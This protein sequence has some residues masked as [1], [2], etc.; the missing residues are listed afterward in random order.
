MKVPI[1]AYHKISD[2]FDWGITAVSKKAFEAQ[3]KYLFENNFQTI[4][5]HQ[6]LNKFGN[7]N[8]RQRPVII[9]FDDADE[10]VFNAAFPILKKYQYHASVFVIS[11]FIGKIN[12]WDANLF[13]RYSKHLS[14]QQL[15]E[16]TTAG[17][18]I[19]S[20]TA[21]HPDLT[22]LSEQQLINELENSKKLIADLIQ[23]PVDYIAY[24][25]NRF[26]PRVLQMA[27]KIG[28]RAGFALS[29][30]PDVDQLLLNFAIPRIGVYSIDGLTNFRKKL[31]FSKFEIR[32]QKWIN[33]FSIGTI[34]YKRL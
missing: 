11:N 24:P 8:T 19:G 17:W 32:K 13:R 23:K 31:S 9:T 12:S 15:K 14:R 21:S 18:E 34:W 27:Q 28:Y 22:R 1:L 10:S 2:D 26:N 25:F 16:L 6:Y 33:Y 20:H 29:I 5:I 7:L 4:S 3:I 30:R